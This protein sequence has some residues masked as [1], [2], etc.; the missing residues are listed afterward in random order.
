MVSS[1]LSIQSITVSV[2]DLYNIVELAFPICVDQWFDAMLLP[3]MEGLA[4]F[5]STNNRK[6][7]FK[8]EK[9]LKDLQFHSFP[10][11][12]MYIC[13][14]K[15]FKQTFF[16]FQ[17]FVGKIPKDLFE[18]ELIPLFEKCG[19]IWDL[20]LMMDPLTGLNRGYC[21]VTFCDKVGAQEGVKQVHIFCNKFVGYTAILLLNNRNF[22]TLS[23]YGLKSQC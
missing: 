12:L 6:N 11:R 3:L 19:R 10:S 23:Y 20:R 15:I 16:L 17:V 1:S 7:R 9:P 14:L 21:F 8:F 18:D 13:L 4:R 22:R 2:P 5:T